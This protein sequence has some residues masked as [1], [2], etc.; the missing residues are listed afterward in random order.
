MN[1]DNPQ[2]HYNRML[3][4]LHWL[5]L[6][7]IAAVYLCIELREMYPKGSD[8]RN[9]MKAWHFMLGL[10]VW[11]LVVLRLVV[12]WFSSIPAIVPAP[13][14]WQKMA[15]WLV[16]VGLYLFMLGMPILG[17]LVVNFE[18]HTVHLFGLE[19]PA[20][21]SPNDHWAEELEDWHEDIGEA[22]YWLIGL[23]A[24]AAL[25]HHYVVKDNTLKRMLSSRGQ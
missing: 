17:L 22:G 5:M 25:F 9:A 16:H 23:H 1:T 10:G 24:A 20:L 13:P 19:I 14:Q 7:L 4:S 18:G 3:I 6:L 11:L 15:S 8:P 12:R 2:T 21:V